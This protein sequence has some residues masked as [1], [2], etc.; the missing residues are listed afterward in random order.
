MDCVMDTPF[1]VEAEMVSSGACGAEGEA[2]G[3]ADGGGAEGTAGGD[4]DDAAANAGGVAGTP[5]GHADDG[6][7]GADEGES[8]GAC[9][10]VDAD[11]GSPEYELRETPRRKRM[12]ELATARLERQ[13]GE[14]KKSA[15]RKDKAPGGDADDAAANAGGVAGTP[16]G[17]ADDGEGGADEGESAGAC[18]EVDADAGSPE[19]ELRET[20]RRK[21]MRELATARLER[22]AGEMKK[23][24]L[25]KD[26]APGVLDVGTIVQVAVSDVD[27]SRVDTPQVKL[28]FQRSKNSKLLIA[29]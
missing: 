1:E 20:P 13:A 8:A 5:G 2:S 23:S 29:Y 25:R 9:A 27:R 3:T 4:A 19:Y 6:E 16:G 26:K 11:A 21:R 24:A 18:A 28:V 10:E 22:Q 12:R 14:M 17:H 7:G 15:L